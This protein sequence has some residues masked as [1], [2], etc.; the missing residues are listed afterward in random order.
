MVRPSWTRDEYGWVPMGTGPPR[1]TLKAQWLHGL[2]YGNDGQ[3]VYAR[4]AAALADALERALAAT[5]KRSPRRRSVPRRPVIGFT[6]R[7]C[8]RGAARESECLCGIFEH[9]TRIAF[10]HSSDSVE[11]AASVSSDAFTI[12]AQAYVVHQAAS[13]G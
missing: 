12:R 5:P 1:G 8:L 10:E 7:R 3:R 11:P 9:R 6:S 4:D 13:R 2:Y